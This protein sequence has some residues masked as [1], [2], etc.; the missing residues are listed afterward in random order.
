MAYLPP[1]PHHLPAWHGNLAEFQSQPE[2][3]ILHSIATA[4]LHDRHYDRPSHLKSWHEKLHL[5]QPALTTLPNN[6]QLHLAYPLLRLSR[7]LDAV[8]ITDHAILALTLKPGAD[9]FAAA[10]RRQTEDGALD[11]HDF[12]TASRHHIV[13]PILIATAA[14][15]QTQ[16]FPLIWHGVTPVFTSTPSQLASLITEITSH[17]P[18]RP[19]PSE[20]WAT[21]PYA[22]VP[23]IIEAATMLY[24]RHGVA[25]I[26]AANADTSNLTATTAAIR[27]AI[28]HARTHQRHIIVF[29]T[30]T[31]GAGK[32]L[33]GLNTVFAETSGAA[34]ITGNLPLVHVLREAL[35]RDAAARGKTLRQAR[36]NTEAALVGLTAFIRDN[37]ARRTPPHEHIV[38]FDEA[39]RAWDEKFGR[40]RFDFHN[41]EAAIC[42]DIMAK[43]T[44]YAVIVA[45]IG[46]GQEI[47][48]G[49]AGL[50]EWGNALA[51]RTTWQIRC[52]QAALTAP[53]PR[54]R[55]FTTP[56]PENLSL[57]PSL[58]LVTSIRSITA[59]TLSTWVNNLLTAQKPTA[60]AGPPITLTRSLQ[61]LKTALRARARGERRAGLLCSSGARRLVAD[62]IWPD[63]P[64]LDHE[65]VEAWFLN[66]WPDIRASDALELPATQFAVQGLELDYVGLCWGGDLVWNTT[67]W[68]PRKFIGTAWNTLKNP[69]AIEFRLNTYRVLLTRARYETIIWVPR[70]DP[71]DPTRE[72]HLLDQTA[73]RLLAAGV[74]PL[75]I[76]PEPQSPPATPAQT[77]LFPA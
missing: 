46:S 60:T 69:D 76:T 4:L 73:E 5:L 27:H 9:K 43:H 44:D 62:G 48:T 32:T 37:I 68:Q 67:A 2:E 18:N 59:A 35:A 52:A 19:G 71:T 29:V 77:T 31:P 17:L 61:H 12:H 64:H 47:N 1:S 39:Q 45:L 33:C 20:T 22:P 3:T 74:Q 65:A 36:Q 41:S 34:F 40:R 51:T 8:L 75:S 58:N 11:L 16:Q 26:A 14:P 55:L 15:P 42:L 49:E 24:A 13:I 63:F 66:R 56:P 25:T 23:T 10:A 38:V 50:S 6:W 70:G 57:N 72:P 53:N 7:R 54:Q 21:A 30:G 28:E